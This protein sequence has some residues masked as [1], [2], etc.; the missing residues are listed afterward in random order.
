ML[1]L[2]KHNFYMKRLCYIYSTPSLSQ[3]LRRRHRRRLRRRWLRRHFG[4]VITLTSSSKFK[5]NVSDRVFK[6]KIKSNS[7]SNRRLRR[8]RLRR[9]FGFVVVTSASSSSI[10]LQIQIQIVGFISRRRDDV[11]QLLQQ[12]L[13]NSSTNPLQLYNSYNR[14]VYCV[15]IEA[16]NYERL[17]FDCTEAFVTSAKRVRPPCQKCSSPAQ[18]TH[19]S[20]IWKLV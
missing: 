3:R 6:F 1:A 7:N 13:Y 14:C 17:R 12:L 5:K 18:S 9:H 11:Q 10:R 19:S 4:F 15:N 8:R 2:H 16:Y 20:S